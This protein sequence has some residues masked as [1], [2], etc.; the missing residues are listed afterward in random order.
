MKEVFV[1]SDEVACPNAENHIGPE[2]ISVVGN[3]EYKCECGCTFEWYSEDSY[4]ILKHGYTN[5]K[6]Q[7]WIV[8][9]EDGL[10]PYWIG[11]LVLMVTGVIILV[12]FAVTAR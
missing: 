7:R 9:R 11:A 2:K 10:T 4:F 5:P 6:G 1:H 3:S 12:G 8:Q